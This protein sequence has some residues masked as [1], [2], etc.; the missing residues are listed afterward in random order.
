MDASE[1][2]FD[3]KQRSTIRMLFARRWLRMHLVGLGCFVLSVATIAVAEFFNI[4]RAKWP[5]VLEFVAACL[6]FYWSFKRGF[7]CPQ[8]NG[9][10]G[11]LAVA[12][13]IR[14]VCYCP[15]CGKDFDSEVEGN[16]NA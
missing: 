10:L 14:S 6:V 15:F 4:P 13:T 9:N 16:G 8:C 3:R 12:G 7:R 1:E 2:D 5:G 11:P